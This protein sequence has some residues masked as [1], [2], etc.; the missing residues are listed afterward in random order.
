MKSYILIFCCLLGNLSFAQRKDHSKTAIA[1]D[2]AYFT[3]VSGVELKKDVSAKT[4][5]KF[6]SELLR[7]VASDLLNGNYDA[8]YRGASYRAYP[9]NASLANTIKLHSGFSRY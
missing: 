1:A 7:Q 9:S 5:K 6:K 8:T 3:D 4:L 2:L